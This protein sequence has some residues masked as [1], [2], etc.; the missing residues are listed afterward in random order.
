M[1]I[2]AYNSSNKIERSG[3]LFYGKRLYRN[4]IKKEPGA[5]FIDLWYSKPLYGKVDEGFHPTFLL[6]KTPINLI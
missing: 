6:R 1:N 3:I 4:E 5:S 2:F